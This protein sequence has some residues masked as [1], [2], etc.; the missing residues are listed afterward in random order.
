MSQKKSEEEIFFVDDEV[1]EEQVKPEKIKAKL[2]KTADKEETPVLNSAKQEALNRALADIEKAFGKGAIMKYGEMGDSANLDIVPTGSLSLDVAL[3]VGGLPRGRIIEIFGQ[4]SSGKT[5]IALSIAASVQ[6][7]G[8]VAA[9]VDAEHA[10]DPS[11][12][13]LL[14]VNVEELYISQPDNGEQALDITEKLA[15]SFAVDVIIVDSVAALIPRQE[16]DAEMG[17]GQV[18]LHAR[19]MS[20]ALKRITVQASKSNCM[21]IFTNQLREKIQT[22]GFGMGPSSTT[23]GGRA[24]KFYASVRIELTYTEKV[25]QG[26]NIIGVHPHIKIAKNKVAPPFKQAEFDIM[27][28]SGISR[29]GELV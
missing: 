3:G 14:G 26:E 9:F 29:E 2:K 12:A 6:R 28:D 13:Q 4:E 11:Y 10:L 16:I 22:S 1:K 17:G 20:R 19:L 21:I 24:L 25:K 18:G 15:K 7:F 27:F 8:G 5:T 23:T